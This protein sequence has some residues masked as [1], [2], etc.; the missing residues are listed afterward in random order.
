[1]L[2]SSFIAL[3]GG[4]WDPSVV[5]VVGGVHGLMVLGLRVAD[6]VTR[7]PLPSLVRGLSLFHF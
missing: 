7:D 1:M 4:Y 6:G 5:A 3:R 2:A